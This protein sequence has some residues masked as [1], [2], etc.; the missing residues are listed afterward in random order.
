MTSEDWVQF[1]GIPTSVEDFVALRDEVAG[2]PEGGAAMMVA[3]LL[4]YTEDE[5]VGRQCLTVAVD[6]QRL[7]EGAKGYK[8]WQLRARDLQM[9]RLQLGGRSYMPRSYVEG[10]VPENGYTLPEP[11]YRFRFVPDPRGD[12]RGADAHIVS[13]GADSARPVTL[14]RNPRGIWKAYEWS[15]LLMG[16]RPPAGDEEDEL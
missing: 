12:E 1:D 7:Q 10:A 16:V 14:H 2:T 6:R 15:S 13:S 4:V 11:P 8:G 9:I 3:A 5:E